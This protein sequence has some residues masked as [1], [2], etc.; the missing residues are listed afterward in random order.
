[1]R[2]SL[3]IV[4]FCATI[5]ATACHAQSGA[6]ARQTDAAP[7]AFAK[8]RS[9]STHEVAPPSPEQVLRAIY[10]IEPSVKPDYDYLVTFNRDGGK[11]ARWWF[12]QRFEFAGKR[13]FTGLAYLT[14][15][16][17]PDGDVNGT[18]GMGAIA[19]VT[20]LLDGGR[21]KQVDQDGYIGQTPLHP[22]S[23]VA[24]E[25]DQDRDVLRHETRDG[26]LLLAVPTHRFDHGYYLFGYELLLFDPRKVD[27][28]HN[29]T[30]AF[31]GEVSAGDD[32]SQ[33][34]G[35]GTAGKRCIES[36]GAVSFMP[37]GDLPDI[38]VTFTGTTFAGGGAVRKLG[39]RDETLYR[40]SAD[41]DS[42]VLAGASEE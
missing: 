40:F 12:G 30:W 23:S 33:D 5:P 27:P 22:I 18:E 39:P 34:C 3:A 14:P 2:K 1:M 15:G 8:S 28:I 13:Y 4:A 36:K 29:G 42:Y 32:N 26:R 21:W 24:S 7:A 41:T 6:E 25:L 19:Q 37:R 10:G 16:D 17:D 9:L 31:V 11:M 20:Y 38:R 35:D